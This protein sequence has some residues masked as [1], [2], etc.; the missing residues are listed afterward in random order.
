MQYFEL[1]EIIT[2]WPHD[3]Y[4]ETLNYTETLTPQPPPI[5][6]T[7]HM[8]STLKHTP[9]LFKHHSYIECGYTGLKSIINVIIQLFFCGFWP[10]SVNL[11]VLANFRIS[12]KIRIFL[13]ENPESLT[14]LILKSFIICLDMLILTENC[15]NCKRAGGRTDDLHFQLLYI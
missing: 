15:T 5:L 4:S 10:H 14:V 7:D 9:I 13:K 3:Q 11:V 8:I 2:F 12:L 6:C 1:L